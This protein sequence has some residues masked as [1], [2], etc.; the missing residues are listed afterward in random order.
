MDPLLNQ[1]SGAHRTRREWRFI[2][3]A[4]LASPEVVAQRGPDAFSSFLL[5]IHRGLLGHTGG[6]RTRSIY[7][8]PDARGASVHYPAPSLVETRLVEIFDHW[9]SHRRSHP[10]FAAVVAMT[11]LM[12][13]HPF[14]DGNGRVARVL[15]HW[16]LGLPGGDRPYLPIHELSLMSGCG[17][18]LRLRQAQ[19]LADW[20]LLFEYLL[21]CA[22]RLFGPAV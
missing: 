12:N 18:L 8:T 9:A 7:S 2:R 10:G 6:F 15:F 17:Y 19:Y 1:A 16:T 4:Q 21:M 20:T 13:L 3:T 5:D 14:A 22:T 11:A